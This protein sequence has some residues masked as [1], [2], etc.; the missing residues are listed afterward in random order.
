MSLHFNEFKQWIHTFKK[1]FLQ[2]NKEENNMSL[3]LENI[4]YDILIYS[5][6]L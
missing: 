1:R 3:L 6:L 5:I 2:K 4:Q